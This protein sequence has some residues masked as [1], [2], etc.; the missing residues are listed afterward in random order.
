MQIIYAAN[1][2]QITQAMFFKKNNHQAKDS[3][4]RF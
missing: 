4:S 2:I 1:Y 3:N